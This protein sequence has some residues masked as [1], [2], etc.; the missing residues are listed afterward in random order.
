EEELA[1]EE[2]G[3]LVVEHVLVP[4][5]HDELGD[6]DGDGVV[7]PSVVELVDVALDRRDQLP[8]R[9]VDDLEGDVDLERPPLLLE[10]LA[11]FFL[12][13]H[14]DGDEVLG[15]ERSR[16]VERLENAAMDVAADEHD[17]GVVDVRLTHLRRF[18][19]E[20]SEE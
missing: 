8:V 13:A 12:E 20:R 5:A 10:T 3:A 11:V 19:L 2:Q 7:V 6:D 9:R 14:V 15:T 18:D 16:V 4:L 1:L 17:N